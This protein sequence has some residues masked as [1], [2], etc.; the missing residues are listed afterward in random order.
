MTAR[1]LSL[2]ISAATADMLIGAVPTQ[3]CPRLPVIELELLNFARVLRKGAQWH[4][5]PS[6]VCVG[7]LSDT[8]ILLP[9]LHF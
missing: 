3:S 1:R 4:V 6:W 2:G 8:C 5:Q 9:F 7:A